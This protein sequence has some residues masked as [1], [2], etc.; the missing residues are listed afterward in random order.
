MRQANSA[1]PTAAKLALET[2]G[3]AECGLEFVPQIH[4]QRLQQSL[5][6]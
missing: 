5:G 3:G 4:A 2:V 6:Y 1:D